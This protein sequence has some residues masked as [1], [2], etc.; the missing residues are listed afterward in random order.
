MFG[1]NQRIKTEFMCFSILRT[2]G[3]DIFWVCDVFKILKFENPF[4]FSVELGYIRNG[5]KC[6]IINLQVICM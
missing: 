4:F 6:S 3:T 2:F 5:I 1:Y